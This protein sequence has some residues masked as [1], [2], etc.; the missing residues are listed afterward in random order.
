MRDLLGFS[1]YRHRLADFHSVPYRCGIRSGSEKIL[2]C[3]Q[4]TTL[5]Q[6]QQ[7]NEGSSHEGCARAPHCIAMSDQHA[8]DRPQ[9]GELGLMGCS[10][11]LATMIPRS[12]VTAAVG[13]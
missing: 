4:L 8:L 6:P 2:S 10:D 9:C 11:M 13:V 7:P 1:D 5:I 3:A 12:L